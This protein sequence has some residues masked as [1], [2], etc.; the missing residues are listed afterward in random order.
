MVAVLLWGATAIAT[1]V[2]LVAAARTGRRAPASALVVVIALAAGAAAASHVALA[3]PGREE[4]LAADFGGGRSLVVEA[5]VVGK[6]ERRA[7]GTLSFDAHATRMGTDAGVRSLSAEVTIRVAPDQVDDRRAL[8]VGATIEA[9]GT[10]ATTRAGARAVL[11]I[12]A[13]RGVVVVSPPDGWTSITSALRAGLVDSAQSLPGEGAGLVPGL[14]VGDTSVVSVELD[15]AMKNSSLSHL[16][17]VS[18][19]NC[20]LVVAIAFGAAAALCASRAIRVCAGLLALAAFVMLVTPEPSVVRA[21]AMA[22]VA[23]IAAL[24]GRPAAGMAILSVAA[25]AVLIGDPWL[26]GSLG[27]ALSVTATA[28]LLLFTRPLARGLGRMMPR[29]L[30]VGLSIPLAAQLACGPLLVLISPNVSLYGVLANLLAAPAAPAATL[31]GLASCLAGAVPV[32]QDGLTAL[33]WVPAT[34]IASTAHVASELP[35]GQVPWEEGW[36]GATGLAIVSLA[37]GILIALRRGTRR[38]T[39]L[40]GASAIVVCVV[41]GGVAG[42]ALLGG[43]AGRWTLPADWSILACDVGQGDALLLRSAGRVALVDT[44]PAPEALAACLGRAGVDRI[45]LLVLTHF[46]VDH[47]GGLA[48]VEDRIGTLLHGPPAPDDIPLLAQLHARGPRLVEA[49]RG[50]TGTLGEARWRV[51]WPV[52]ESRAYPAGNDASV[53]LDVR[54]GGIPPT[55]LLGDL[56]ASPQRAVAATDAFDPPYAVIKVAH[57]G[58]ADQDF[59]LYRAAAP[60]LALI[61]VGAQNDY[62]HPREEILRVLRDGR[63]TVARTDRDGVIAVWSARGAVGVWRERGRRVGSPR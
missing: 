17:A 42:G 56:S 7:D 21:A 27:F 32:L 23:M 5:L 30:A 28:S 61:S 54:G 59:E 36:V 58:S 13:S 24:L 25:S 19:A 43:V 1:A 63:T 48:A 15:A 60:T 4:V 57:H 14:A 11:D 53:T 16:T 26:A 12:R 41:M 20:A 3:L 10:A 46:D 45:D 2:M 50:M 55:L 22:A 38:R 8:D 29:A 18:G 35:G 9:H 33:A 51:L 62:G 34:W 6:V 37:A 47:A 44:G 52:A 49:D 40:R 39:I 31:V